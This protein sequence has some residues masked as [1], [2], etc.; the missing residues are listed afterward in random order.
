MSVTLET[1]KVT[2]LAKSLDEL[3]P[4][5]QC[6]E[7]GYADCLSYAEAISTSQESIALCKP[8]G[9]TVLNALS[10]RLALDPA[11]YLHSVLAAYKAPSKVRI[12]AELCIGCT[13]CIQAC[14]VDAII[15]MPKRMHA[16]LEDYCS[17]CDLCIEPCPVDCIEKEPI[18]VRG[19]AQQLAFANRSRIRYQHRQQRKQQEQDQIKKR[20]QAAQAWLESQH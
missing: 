8:G 2:A 15:G 10:Q 16:V 4:Q 11:P 1:K 13:K 3:L 20:F 9:E 7:C 12:D 6:Q 17:G 18:A 19:Q 14:P 5:T